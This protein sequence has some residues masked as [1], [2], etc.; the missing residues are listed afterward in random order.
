MG[1]RKPDRE[2]FDIVC[3]ENGLDAANTLFIDDSSQNIEGAKIAGLNVLHCTA[4][5]NLE[6]YFS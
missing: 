5:V 4:S 2:I 6:E 3:Q 1:M